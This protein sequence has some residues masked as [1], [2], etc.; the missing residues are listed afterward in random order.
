MVTEVLVERVYDDGKGGKR[1]DKGSEVIRPMIWAG[2]GKV[3]SR[4]KQDCCQMVAHGE[5]GAMK[6]LPQLAKRV[7]LQRR[8]AP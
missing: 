8:D 3:A 5:T 4:S 1:R 2:S 7:I 6:P